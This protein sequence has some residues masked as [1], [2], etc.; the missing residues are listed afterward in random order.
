MARLCI[1]GEL[2]VILLWPGAAVPVKREPEET[3]SAVARR[4]GSVDPIFK[5]F[6]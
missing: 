4:L 3:A 2:R 5:V 6:D 1:L